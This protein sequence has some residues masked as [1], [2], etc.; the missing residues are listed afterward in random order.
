V[1]ILEGKCSRRR[2]KP[3]HLQGHLPHEQYTYQL[4]LVKARVKKKVWYLVTNEKVQTAEQAWEIVFAYRRRWQ[5]EL[6]F[7]YGK[8]ELALECPR[9]YAM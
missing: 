3:A 7:R 9:L 8:S 6:S 1:L 2:A 5:I 4:Y